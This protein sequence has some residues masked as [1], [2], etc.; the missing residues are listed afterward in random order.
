MDESLRLPPFRVTP[1]AIDKIASLG[2][3]LR[4]GVVPGGCSGQAFEFSTGAPEP[5]APG[6]QAFGCPDAWL[7]VHDRALDVMRGAILDY[8]ERL[9]PPRFRILRNPSASN[10][11]PC[12]RSFGEPWPGAGSPHCRSYLPMPWDEGFDPPARWKRQTGYGS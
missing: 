2:G 11:C 5:A 12:R 9:R 3:A 8:S 6:W 7:H 1:A 4:L 10:P